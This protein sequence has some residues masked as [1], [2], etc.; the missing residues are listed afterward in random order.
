M[1]KIL[2]DYRRPLGDFEI[3]DFDT[4]AT[5]DRL[6]QKVDIAVPV[7]LHWTWSYD[8]EID[9]LRRLYEKG[10]GGGNGTHRQILI[11][12]RLSRRTS[13]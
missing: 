9:E 1:D 3:I 2:S 11:G 6:R 10:K 4:D 12:R 5:I 8:S 13:G 7:S